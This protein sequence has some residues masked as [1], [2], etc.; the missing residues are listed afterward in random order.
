VLIRPITL[1]DVS[2]RYVDWLRDPE[3]N[4]YLE[5]RHSE[6]TLESVAAFVRSILATPDQHLFAICMMPEER[7]VG[8]IKVGPIKHPHGLADV[9]LFIGDRGAWGQGVATAAIKLIS[10]FA[11]ERLGLRKLSA[12]VYAPNTGS[13][14]AFLRAGY[15]QEGLRR[16]HYLMGSEM[17]DAL[18]FGLCAE[19][20]SQQGQPQ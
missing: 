12:G 9:S 7:H 13:A 16:R 2:P 11:I 3:V 15:Q 14:K 18:E 5:T 19:D 20:L 10:R 17:V 4:Q 1:D 6:Q 8:N